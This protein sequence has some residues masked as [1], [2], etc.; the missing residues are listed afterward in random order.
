VPYNQP[1]P[2]LDMLT[3]FLK[4]EDFYDRPLVTF[5]SFPMPDQA[6]QSATM[7]NSQR[8][9]TL[10]GATMNH[11]QT[12]S[13][14][15]EEL[16][17]SATFGGMPQLSNAN[18]AFSGVAIGLVSLIAVTAFVLGIGVAKMTMTVAG[19]ASGRSS[20]QRPLTEAEQYG[21]I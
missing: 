20:E 13:K 18:T 8:E 17:M 4:G 1:G 15:L 11:S 21:S 10:Q 5:S 7:N 16:Q 14:V 9:E 3:R 2:A 6:L 12:E 19:T